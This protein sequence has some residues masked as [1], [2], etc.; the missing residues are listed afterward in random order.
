DDVLQD[1]HP[2]LDLCALHHRPGRR[3]RQ[4]DADEDGVLL[5]LRGQ[6]E[7]GGRCQR[8]QRADAINDHGGTF[9]SDVVVKAIY[10]ACDGTSGRGNPRAGPDSLAG[11]RPARVSIE[12]TVSASSCRWNP[13]PRASS[14][15][16]ATSSRRAKT[17][18]LMS[19]TA[20]SQGDS[21]V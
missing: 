7:P 19:S 6:G 3:L 13:S 21:T 12:W 11:S 14:R 18:R 17:H 16:T 1:L 2:V 20:A 5:C 9:E 15:R 4:A 10:P 8:G